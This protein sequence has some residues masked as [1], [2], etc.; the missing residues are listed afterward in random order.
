MKIWNRSVSN[1]GYLLLLIFFSFCFLPFQTAE[2]AEKILLLNRDILDKSLQIGTD[3]MISHQ[4]NE[5]NFNYEYDWIKGTFTK[6]DSEVRQAGAAWGLALIYHETGQDIVLKALERALSFFEGHSRVTPNGER[7]ISYPGAS[8]GSTGTVALC[9]LAHIELLRSLEEKGIPEKERVDQYRSVLDGYI[10]FLVK[11]RDKNGLWH[12]R[13]STL[14]GKPYG[15][16]SPY[17]DGES[18]LALTKAVKYLGMKY[19]I[20]VIISS[21]ESGYVLNVREALEKD[22]DSNITKGYFQW[23]SMSYYELA[24]LGLDNSD[25]YGERL[26]E[27]SDWMIDVHK[28]LRRTR[29]TAYAYEGIIHAYQWA[30]TKDYSSKADKYRDTIERGLGKLSTWQVGSPVANSFIRKHPTADPL[31]IGGVQNHRSESPLRIDVTQ[32]QMHAVILARRYVFDK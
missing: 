9:A 3:F 1:K 27:L 19:L 6:G 14:T 5:G 30:R 32:H 15:P 10:A 17:F 28:T 8:E 22:P 12:S 29:N 25:S 26:M 31:A 2:G 11:A 18:L 16:S 4:N 13:Y 21:A 24:D 7:Y 23:A 20:P